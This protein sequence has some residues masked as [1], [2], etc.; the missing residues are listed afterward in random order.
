[1]RTY[2]NNSGTYLESELAVVVWLNAATKN[3]VHARVLQT[4][5]SHESKYPMAFPL[6]FLKSSRDWRNAS[7][8]KNTK[9]FIEVFTKTDSS[10][11]LIVPLDVAREALGWEDFHIP[12]EYTDHG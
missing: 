3:H 6:K 9:T 7:F 4:M 10:N 12:T 11:P 2:R 5:T 1:M 8:C